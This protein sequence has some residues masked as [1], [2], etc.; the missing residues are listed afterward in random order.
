MT[1]QVH[2]PSP[3]DVGQLVQWYI[4]LRTQKSE[5]KKS[6]E[7]TIAL[8]DDQMDAI[9]KELNKRLLANDLTSMRTTNG[10]VVRVEKT[11]FSVADAYTLKEWLKQNPDVGINLVSVSANTAELTEYLAEGNTLPEGMAFE[12]IFDI[13]IRRK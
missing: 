12:K 11:K 2:D 9:E 7:P 13:S 6:I 8:I 4:D 3:Y 1:N 5:V 10:T